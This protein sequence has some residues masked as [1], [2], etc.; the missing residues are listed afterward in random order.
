MNV[1]PRP[2]ETQLGQHIDRPHRADPGK[3][4]AIQVLFGVLAG[5]LGVISGGRTRW[6]RLRL[7][8][9]LLLLAA[10]IGGDVVRD[11]TYRYFAVGEPERAVA[12]PQFPARP[13]F[14]LMGGGADVD[15]A[16]RWMIRKAG[17]RPGSGGRFVV[18]RASG[19]GAYDPY[20][21]FSGPGRQTGVP[22]AQRWVGGAALGLSSAETLVIPSRAAAESPFVNS[23]VARAN[24]VFIAGGDQGNYIRHWKGTRL[25]ST[26]N[27]LL[28]RKVPVGGTSAGLAI[29]GAFDFA[30]LR[31]TINSA[32]ALADPFDQRITLDPGP[33]APGGGL[34]PASALANTITDSHFAAGRISQRA[35]CRTRGSLQRRP[36]TSCVRS[37]RR[38]GASPGRR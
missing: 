13:A 12:I 29:L 1:H 32:R 25:E 9:A 19:T 33:L 23:V 38:P 5:I 28:A 14:V 31:G 18:L 21:F 26:L 34:L 30:A 6:R 2:E 37:R 15:E 3:R 17:V 4:L 8:A 24:A 11:E 20:I 35:K 10:L 7:G 36:S 16:F 22:V 27:S